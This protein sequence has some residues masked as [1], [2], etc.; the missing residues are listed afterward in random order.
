[1]IRMLQDFLHYSR[2]KLCLLKAAA[3]RLISGAIFSDVT[4]E[5]E[6]GDRLYQLY[7]LAIYILWFA[8]MWFY[9]LD[10]TAKIFFSMGAVFTQSIMQ[11]ALFAPVGIFVMLAF[12][13]SR[14]SPWK[15]SRPDISY[16]AGSPIKTESIILRE[17]MVQLL[18]WGVISFFVGVLL[19]VGFQN[20]L[21]V[22][23][24]PFIFPVLGV[25]G[26]LCA[27]VWGWVI[28]TV[29]LVVS[30]NKARVFFIAVCFVLFLIL[31]GSI[32]LLASSSVSIEGVLSPF[33]PALSVG[34]FAFG[35]VVLLKASKHIDV[36]RAIE[37]NAFYAD[38]YN[39]R[40]MPLYDVVGHSEIQ[41]QKRVA[42]RDPLFSMR[43]GEGAKALLM[44]SLVS[45]LRQYEGI[46]SIVFWGAFAAPM[47][48]ILLLTSQN[49]LLWMIWVQVLLMMPKG[50]REITRVFR[51]DLRNS[52]IR[53]HLPFDSL[54]LFFYDSV[55]GF[56]LC[57]GISIVAMLL[58]VGIGENFLMGISICVA[59]NVVLVL[60]SGI[61]KIPLF[62]KRRNMSYEGTA[63]VFILGIFLTSLSGMPVLSLSFLLL[64]AFTLTVVL[65]Y[66]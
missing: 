44:R 54:R 41:R 16:V 11:C 10:F 5:K 45:H 55:I 46:P 28:G 2:L 50:V 30:R 66:S 33:F 12:Q 31:I 59:T 58:L 14:S 47:T 7:G 1:M 21:G 4:G 43:T 34:M 23:I 40:Y 65:K 18:V 3:L 42:K 9:L 15:M 52:A 62:Q 64:Y 35:L 29:R 26:S 48:T 39:L 20:G 17:V 19:G 8:L 49:P 51:D 22:E 13:Y 36:T 60:C 27:V 25:L 53:D 6:L 63:L 56:I 37:E 38:M 24:S 32:S 61:D 57:V